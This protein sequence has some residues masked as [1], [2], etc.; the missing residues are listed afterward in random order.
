M[1][2]TAPAGSE[3]NQSRCSCGFVAWITSNKVGFQK[4]GAPLCGGTYN[5]YSSMRGGGAYQS[6]YPEWGDMDTKKGL[7]HTGFPQSSCLG[8]SCLNLDYQ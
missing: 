8:V 6:G 5:K 2:V 3:Y 7:L 1:R 4:A